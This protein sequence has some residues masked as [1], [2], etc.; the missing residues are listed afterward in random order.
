MKG[1]TLPTPDGLVACEEAVSEWWLGAAVVVL[2]ERIAAFVYFIPTMVKLQRVTAPS[3]AAETTAARWIYLNY[4][5]TGI[6]LA[7]WIMALKA[8]ALTK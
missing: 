1:Q 5:R 4:V 2:I 7:A 3:S 6:Y 8:L